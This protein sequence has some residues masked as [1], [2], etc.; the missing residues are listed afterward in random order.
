MIKAP[1]KALHAWAL[2]APLY[3]LLAAIVALPEIVALALSFTDYSI[4]RDPRWIGEVNYMRTLGSASFWAAALRTLIFVA[5]AVVLEAAVGLLLACLLIRRIPMRG[6]AIA[7]LIAPIAMSHAVTATIWAYLLDF[8][9]GPVN[10]VTNLMGLGRIPWLTEAGT[11]LI[12]VALIEFWA[13]MPHVLVMLYPVRAAFPREI[14]EAGEI[15]GATPF[16]R[17]RYLTWPMIRPAFLIAV[18]FRIIITFRAFGVVWILTK[19][20]PVD[21]SEILSVHLYKIGF[22]YWEFGR[23]ASIAW[24]MLLL[25]AVVS[26]W[27]MVRLYRESFAPKEAA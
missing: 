9:V 3:A 16:Q 21:A 12:V 6:L 27:A 25:T 13:G 17:F 24:L 22:V 7:C 20:G 8:N 4:G 11:A 5:I 1:S 10:Y 15:D 23:A 18:V 2:V 26:S 14:Y 19:G